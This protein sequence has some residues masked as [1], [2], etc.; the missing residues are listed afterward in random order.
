VTVTS[1]IIEKPSQAPPVWLDLLRFVA[2]GLAAVLLQTSIAANIG[3]LG[4]HPDFVLI[5]VV[6]VALLRGAEA[7]AV[8]GFVV[9]GLVSIPLFEPAGIGAFVMVIVGYL[10]GR[11]AETVD[12]SP[13]ILPIVTVLVTSLL[14]ETLYALAQFLL[15]REAPAYFIATHVIVPQAILN[16]LLAAP[17]FL[18]VH[19][20][21]GGERHAR[22][23]EAR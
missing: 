6:S 23:L 12:L 22:V 14:G 3:I 15:E 9:G 19:W 2:V 16:T 7:G 17:V 21:F 13:G 1:R 20:I 8:F 5:I 10:S 18:I 11:Y 4:A